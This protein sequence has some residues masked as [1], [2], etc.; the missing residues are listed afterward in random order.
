M[1]QTTQKA[2]GVDLFIEDRWKLLKEQFGSAV[3]I[4]ARRRTGLERGKC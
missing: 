3:N 2:Q 1:D 4:S